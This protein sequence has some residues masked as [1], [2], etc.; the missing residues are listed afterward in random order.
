VVSL[1]PTISRGVSREKTSAAIFRCHGSF[2][3]TRRE[4]G[5]TSHVIL[6]KIAAIGQV[7]RLRSVVAPNHLPGGSRKEEL[8][9]E[10][11]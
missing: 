2:D 3:N 9:V 5:L 10:L 11:C 6:G 7:E 4:E 1:R 8:G